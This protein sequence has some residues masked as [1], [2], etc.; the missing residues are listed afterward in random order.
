MIYLK[1]YK[2]IIKSILH[3]QGPIILKI[4]ETIHLATISIPA[5][6]HQAS[7]IEFFIHLHSD[8]H[9]THI[10]STIDSS[11]EATTTFF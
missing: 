7:I 10:F 11:P 9:V 1:P 3:S 8:F 5:F 6:S 2:N 4:A